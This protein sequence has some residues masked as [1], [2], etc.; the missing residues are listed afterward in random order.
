MH[1][2]KGFSLVELL[3]VIGIIAVL[4]ALILPTLKKAKDNANR[5]SCLNNLR[6]LGLGLRM[7]LQ[8]GDGIYPASAC[9][10]QYEDWIYWNHGSLNQGRLVPYTSATGIFDPRLYTCPSDDPTS[11]TRGYPY[12]YSVSYNLFACPP[13][14]FLSKPFSRV[15][16]PSNCIV[17]VEESSLTIDD[18][19][20]AWT[21]N[22]GA[23]YNIISTR[24]D[25]QYLENDPATNSTAGNGNVLFADG[26]ADWIPRIDT[27]NPYYYDPSQ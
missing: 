12:S 19:C 11:H 22:Y 27:F 2:R 15:R 18:G 21:N 26:H 7:Y 13:A 17:M 9:S 5:V 23:G 20:W 25:R 24:H 1:R 10:S 4:V 3:V 16:H 6:Q 8:A 14:G